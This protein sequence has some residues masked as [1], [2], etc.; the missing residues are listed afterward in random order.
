MITHSSGEHD[1]V[2][3][4]NVIIKSGP[5]STYHS[6]LGEKLLARVRATT[7]LGCFIRAVS[8]YHCLLISMFANH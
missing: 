3:G 5:L 7:T 2:T 4:V 8:H 6:H 1:G